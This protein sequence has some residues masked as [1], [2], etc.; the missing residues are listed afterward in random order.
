ML[1]QLDGHRQMLIRITYT[2]HYISIELCIFCGVRRHFYISGWSHILLYT[3]MS[4]LNV[5]R[6]RW[7]GVSG[8]SFVSRLTHDEYEHGNNINNVFVT[9]LV[10]KIERIISTSFNTVY[11]NE[12]PKTPQPCRGRNMSPVHR[13]LDPPQP[14]SS[15]M[16]WL[17]HI[18]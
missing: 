8:G 2:Q 13:C 18:L 9:F 5:K 15:M 7:E 16:V 12:R 3:W 11:S 4:Y 1:I 6:L 17:V 14:T 10:L